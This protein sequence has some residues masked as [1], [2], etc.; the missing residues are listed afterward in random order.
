MIRRYIGSTPAPDVDFRLR[1]APE[2]S[3]DTMLNNQG[4]PLQ[5]G[6]T[7]L[8][9]SDGLTDLVWDDEISE[10]VRSKKDLKSA[11]QTLI[12]LANERGGRRS[13]PNVPSPS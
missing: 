3:D 12:E 8:L 5:G 2:Q 1:T 7:L 9:C 6:D 11:A 10:I 4:M 13:F